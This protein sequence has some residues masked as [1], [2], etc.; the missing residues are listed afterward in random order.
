MSDYPTMLDIQRGLDPDGRMAAVAEILHQT[1][2]MMADIPF[3]EGNLPT[4]HRSTIRSGLP[5]PTF[6]AFYGAVQPTKSTRVQVTDNTAMMEAYA[7]VDKALADLN[8]NTAAFRASED[9]AHIEGMSQAAQEAF[10]YGNS[11]IN[12]TQF[13]GLAPRFNSL[14]AENADNIINCG[15]SGSDNASIWLI[16]WGQNTVHGIYPKGSQGGLQMKDLGEI[17]KQ[18]V[19]GSGGMYQVY[20]THYRWDLGL[21]VKDWRYIV[22]A[23]NIDRSAL[24][25]DAAT[26]TNLPNTMFSMIHRLPSMDLGQCAFYMDRSL[27]E[28]YQT[29]M[30]ALVKNSSLTLENVG[31]VKSFMFQ[32]IPIRRV[33]KMRADEAAVA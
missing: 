30:A 12:P 14:S 9:V 20:L 27:V 1:N 18:D 8:G 33:D 16:C 13:N 23:C 24:T 28:K 26:G 25:I 7:E 6:R 21:V 4:G 3:F 32:G 22:R 19:D 5:A 15:G 10:I 31:G 17:T 29:Q 11:S 2:Q